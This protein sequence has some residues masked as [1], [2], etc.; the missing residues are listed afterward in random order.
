LE[1]NQSAIYKY[2]NNPEGLADSFAASFYVNKDK[3]FPI[4]PFGVFAELGIHFVFRN[5]NKLEGILIPSDCNEN[6]SLVAINYKR[7]IQRQR[8]TAAHELCHIIKDVS[9]QTISCEIGAKTRTERF[10]ES[11]ASA[12]LIPKDELQKKINNQLINNFLSCDDILIIAEYF[13]VSFQA[14]TY[15]IQNCFPKVLPENLET[16]IKKYK[17]SKRRERFGFSNTNLYTSILNS[18]DEYLWQN[19]EN[20]MA[21]FRFKNDYVYNDARLEN[22]ETT[23]EAVSE[24]VADLRLNTQH[25]QYCQQQYSSFT[26]IAGHSKLYDYIFDYSTNNPI[27]VFDILKLNRILFS[28]AVCPDFGGRTRTSNVMVIGAKFESCDYHDITSKLLETEKEVKSLDSNWGIMSKSE[29]L[30]QIVSIHHQLTVIHPFADGNGRTIR[31]FTNLQLIR[32]GIPPVF[33]YNENKKIYLNALC[34]A[35]KGDSSELFE[36]FLRELFRSH[37]DFYSMNKSQKR[38]TNQSQN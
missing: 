3:T 4:N 24:I 38:K 27:S 25:S 26:E 28:C 33:I 15:R 18:W 21:S 5:L 12:F 10:A 9:N 13:G 37:A 11:F 29:V 30:R 34:K 36:V 17:P 2:H 31:A 14:C 8:Y 32:Y 6:S 23:P 1:F 7:P 20:T 16:L 19:P 22:I 35:D